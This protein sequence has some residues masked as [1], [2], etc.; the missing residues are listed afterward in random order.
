MMNSSHRDN[1]QSSMQLKCHDAKNRICWMSPFV[2]HFHVSGKSPVITF[3]DDQEAIPEIL[4]GTIG[5]NHLAS[6][7]DGLVDHMGK[8]PFP[9]IPKALRKTLSD[10]MFGPSKTILHCEVAVH[11]AKH[12]NTHT[13]KSHIVRYKA[14]NQQCMICKKAFSRPCALKTHGFTH[15]GEKPYC[16]PIKECM[17]RFS[18]R[19]NLKRHTS[20]MHPNI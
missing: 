17:H 16:C 4:N 12:N 5:C 19:S 2:D 10:T 15:T 14:I 11:N 18:V 7:N 13:K 6:C 3:L 8:I 1:A 9:Q 20:T